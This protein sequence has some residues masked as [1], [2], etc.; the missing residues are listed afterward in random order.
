M[1]K[2]TILN[3]ATVFLFTIILSSRSQSQGNLVIVGGGLEDTNTSVYNQLIAFA[4]GAGKATFA[5]IPAASGVSIQSYTYFRN[6]LVSYGVKPENIHLINIALVDDDSTADVDES[7]WSNNGNDTGLADLV[8]SCSAVWFTGGDQS[9]V[10][11]ALVRPDGSKTPVLEAVWEVFRSGGVIGGSSAGAAIMSEAMICGGNSL[12]ALTHGVI[13]DYQGDDFPEGDGLLMS[14]GLGF[15]P[16]GI[17]DQHFEKRCRLGRL[18]MALMHEKPAFNKGF[19]IDENTALIYISSQNLVKV[20][21]ASGIT[22]IDATNATISYFQKLPEI[23]NLVVSYLEKDD[24]YNATSGIITP[25]A[26][27][28]P[29]R[30]NEYNN[31]Q[32]PGQA[33]ILSANSTSFRDL[34]TTNLLDNKGADTVRNISFSDQNSGFLVTLSKT[35]SSAGFYTDKPNDEDRFTVTGIRM[36]ISPVQ[37]TISPMK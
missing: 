10:L 20:A 23:Q 25:A 8:R 33:G 2:L 35:P 12:A 26:G 16:L 11:K 3:I 1:T 32:N 30:G 4:G 34:I 9:R 14:K 15:F 29:T 27:K 7:S 6:T 17:V 36:D 18:V 22:M 31:I 5:V 24:T 37:V 28:K 21:G 19:G 13:T